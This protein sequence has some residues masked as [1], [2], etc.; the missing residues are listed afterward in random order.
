[1]ELMSLLITAE[2]RAFHCCHL[3]LLQGVFCQ[4]YDVNFPSLNELGFLDF[5]LPE[6]ESRAIVGDILVIKS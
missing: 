6:V 5:A 2:N 1:M 4:S 3:R